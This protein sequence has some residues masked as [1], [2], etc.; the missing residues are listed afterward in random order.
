MGRFTLIR[1]AAIRKA[2]VRG[3]AL[4]SSAVL[5]VGVG[6]MT[7]GTA[8]A[9]T[10]NVIA[11]SVPGTLFVN[12]QPVTSH[13]GTSCSTAKYATIQAAVDAASAGQTVT[14]CAGSYSEDVFVPKA[15]AL[16]GVGGP[17]INATATSTHNCTF[18]TG[19]P[20][21]TAPCLAG[22][23]IA[24]SNVSVRG[25]T[26]QGAQGEGILAT[27]SLATKS[28]ISISITG[29]TVTGNDLGGATSPY[30]Q[31]QGEEADCGE[32]VHL[33]GVAHSVVS[34]NKIVGNSGGILVTDEFGPTHANLISH[35]VVTDN[36]R[37]CGITMPGHNPFAFT[38]ATRT[39][40]P[41][42]AGVY[43]NT[44][45]ANIVTGNGTSG[46]GAGVLMAVPIP[47]SASY[48]NLVTGNYIAGNGL[49]GVTLHDHLPGG[50]YMK[51]N[52]IINNTIGT[53][54][55]LGDEFD[56][57]PP[58]PLTVTTGITVYSGAD[59]VSITI[60][61]NLIFDDTDGVWRT[62]NVTIT[63]FSTNVFNSVTTPLFS[64]PPQ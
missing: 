5:I 56:T 26:V 28:I 42:V 52:R 27:G 7:A 36:V 59:P 47:G 19:G 60:A 22:I 4:A 50:A 10:S 53:N 48:N 18:L 38:T 58:L 15:L 9:V 6:V 17:V 55:V 39:L 24:A 35:N 20:P 40:D 45:E 44:V 37:D 32:G 11:G 23:T 30:P 33:M 63:G 46:F 12:N 61:N 31:C 16:I 3:A 54:N 25:F 51:G 43:D 41:T 13:A 49:A 8:S 57:N 21:I 62:T 14:V 34:N 29:N 64:T 2:A 1:N